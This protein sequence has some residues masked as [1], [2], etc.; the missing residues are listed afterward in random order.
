MSNKGTVVSIQV[1]PAKW[2]EPEEAGKKRTVE[3]Q[4]MGADKD[5]EFYSVFLRF[6]NGDVKHVDDRDFERD[7]TELANTLCIEHK[8]NL[9]PYPWQSARFGIQALSTQ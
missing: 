4:V 9:E 3:T 2:V 6:Q 8:V 5:T 7:A 1:L